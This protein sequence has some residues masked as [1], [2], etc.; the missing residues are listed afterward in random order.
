MV[1]DPVSELLDAA[2]S[3]SSWEAYERPLFEQLERAI[4]FDVAFC[5][6]ADGVIGPHAPGIDPRVRQATAGRFGTYS[7]EYG[8]LK[9]KA[10]AERGVAVDV[11][12]FGR[13]AFE[14]T[15]AYREVIQPHGGR[16]S[17][18][19]YLGTKESALTLIVLG[20]TRGGFRASECER[21]AAARSLLTVCEQAVASRQLRAPAGPD[22]TRREREL[23]QYLRLGY[24]NPEIASAC[25]TSYRTVRNQL[26]HLFEKL[27]VSTRAEAV[28]RSFELALPL[29]QSTRTTVP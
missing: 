27:E 14:R 5:L 22:L 7:Q 13:A 4:G 3:A 25:G 11:E 15:H 12:F 26:S 20:R 10:L 8:P 16:S 28:A 23:L 18:L 9:R 1:L 21:A 2:V 17:L 24:T 29:G 6:R 19:L